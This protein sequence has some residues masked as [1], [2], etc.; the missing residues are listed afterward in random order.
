MVEMEGKGDRHEVGA[1]MVDG[2]WW[3]MR[4]VPGTKTQRDIGVVSWHCAGWEQGD[5]CV[6]N[7]M[8][9]KGGNEN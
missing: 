9:H 8:G 6:G 5:W 4:T 7:E 3:A 2:A 1:P